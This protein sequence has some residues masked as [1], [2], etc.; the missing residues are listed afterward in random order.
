VSTVEV[1]DDA[2]AL[3]AGVATRLLERLEEI[4]AAG[5]IPQ[6]VLTGG[7]IADE[8]HREV[9]RLARDSSVDWARVEFWWGDERYVAADS[10]DRNALQAHT[11]LLDHLPVDPALV[12]AMPSAEFGDLA[13]AATAYGVEVRESPHADEFDV[14]MLGIG[15]DGHVASLFPGFPQLD[16]DDIALPVTGSPKPPPERI[17]LTLAALSRSVAVWFLVSGAAKADAVAQALAGA[18]KHDIPATGVTGMSET[19]WLIDEAAAGTT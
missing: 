3:A 10:P 13:A 12:H 1:Y 15:P 17:T 11:A 9:A 7:T 16:V 8:V 14:V 2:G 19:L 5:R 6:V 18:D 4:Q